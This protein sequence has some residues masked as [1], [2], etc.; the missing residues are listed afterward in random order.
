MF[1]GF[2]HNQQLMEFDF[3][4]VV[5]FLPILTVSSHFCWCG[6]L[7]YFLLSSGCRFSIRC[8]WRLRARCL[9]IICKKN[10]IAPL[11]YENLCFY[12]T[13]YPRFPFRDFRHLAF[14]RC[15]SGLIQFIRFLNC[16]IS[17]FVWDMGATRTSC[18]SRFFDV[19]YL[20]LRNFFLVE[21]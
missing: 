19:V 1:A 2:R 9:L 16:T 13:N 15:T 10:S 8:A 4:S 6:L 17:T 7:T 11:S 21:N 20:L 3:S 12:F 5:R 14:L 18:G